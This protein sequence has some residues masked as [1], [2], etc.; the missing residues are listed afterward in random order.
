M[1]AKR[2]LDSGIRGYAAFMTPDEELMV[3]FGALHLV[4]LVLGLILFVM[5]L[6]SEAGSSFKPPDED[7]GG[8]G[9]NDR[10]SDK[11]KNSPS[12]G[13]PLP[14]ALQSS[15]RLRSHERLRDAYRHRERRRV[16][17]PARPSR[18]RVTG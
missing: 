2:G 15:F 12:G 9:G 16:S 10:V 4:A 18:R 1:V 11:P 5:F 13:I 8:G 14:D 17:E 3:I 6:R 7:D